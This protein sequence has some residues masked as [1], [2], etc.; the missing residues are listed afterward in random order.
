MKKK[1]DPGMF[2]VPLLLA[3]TAGFILRLFV[4]DILLVEGGSM[5]PRIPAGSILL[6]NRMAYGIRL[7]LPPRYILRWG[8]PVREDIVVYSDTHDGKLKIKRIAAASDTLV[9][10]RGDNPALSVDSRLHGSVPVEKIVGKVL[11][12]LER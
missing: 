10:L 8:R 1:S 6:I 9:F 12:S 3:L 5:E 2:A 11:V 7:P 4:L